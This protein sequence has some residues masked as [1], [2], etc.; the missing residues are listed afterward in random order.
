MTTISATVAAGTSDL[1]WHNEGAGSFSNTAATILIGD[2][3][4]ANNARWGLIRVTGLTIPVGATITSANVVLKPT[5]LTGTIP[6]MTVYGVLGD[7]LAAPTTRALANALSLSTASV[8]WTPAGWTVGNLTHGTSP[9]LKTIFQEIVNQGT[10]TSG[11]AIMIVFAVPRDAFGSANALSF[12]AYDNIPADAAVVNVTYT[13]AFA[14]VADAGD[15]QVD[16]VPFSTVTLDGTG[17]TGSP[18]VYAWT[19]LSGPAVTLSS[20]SDDN[21]TFEAPALLAGA[22]L[23]FG[24]KVGDGVTLSAQDTVQIDV[25]P[26]DKFI[27]KGGAWVPFKVLTRNDSDAWI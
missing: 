17:S 11:D 25:L 1:S 15:D 26:H 19:Q 23:V 4:A 9:E 24:L 12:R 14:G 10:W 22:T 13:T 21:P 2:S 8:G 16:L 20:S 6:P 18:S 5:G 27:R 3:D 7:N